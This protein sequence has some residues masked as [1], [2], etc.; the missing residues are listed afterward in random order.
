MS[1]IFVLKQS[2]DVLGHRFAAYMSLN[3]LTNHLGL[4]I[5][6]ER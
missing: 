2:V 5:L 4:T 3:G 1:L 6:V